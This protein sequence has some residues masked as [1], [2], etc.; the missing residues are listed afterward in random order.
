MKSIKPILILF[1]VLLVAIATT[2]I[3]MAAVSFTNPVDPL[4]ADNLIDYES[5]WLKDLSGGQNCPNVSGFGYWTNETGHMALS[6]GAQKNPAD[7]GNGSAMQFDASVQSAISLL[8]GEDAYVY[9]MVH[10]PEPHNLLKFSMW[11]VL[12]NGGQVDVTIFGCDDQGGNC[13]EVWQAVPISDSPSSIFWEPLNQRETAVSQSYPIYKI[14]QHCRYNGGNAGCK[15]TGYYFS[16][17]QSGQT[18]TATP[19]QTAVPPTATQTPMSTNTAVPPTATPDPTHTP[20][21]TATSLPGS[22]SVIEIYAAGRL[23]T[24]DIELFIDG[25]LVSTFTNIGGDYRA[26]VFEV[27]TYT[28]NSLVSSDQVQVHLVDTSLG[29]TPGR[30]LR[31]DKISIDG[32]GYQ[33]EDEFVYSTGTW[34]GVDGCTP[35]FKQS[36]ILHLTCGGY[37][38]YRNQP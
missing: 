8:P 36:E 21:P 16:V 28:H 15:F 13:V 31:V 34:T 19:T 10:A 2:T 14:R 9:L 38:E 29:D 27:F 25:A 32:Q 1:V 35:G 26:G 33:S 20:L 17:E 30:T 12:R 18:A 4:P 5:A 37:F 24:E 23:G 7:E 6:C 11:R 22:G 3:T